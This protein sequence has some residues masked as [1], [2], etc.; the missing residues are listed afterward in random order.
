MIVT[1]SHNPHGYF[2]NPH[3]YDDSERWTEPYLAPSAWKWWPLRRMVYLF[4]LHRT[5][6]LT[7]VRADGTRIQPD[8]RFVTDW[9]STPKMLQIIAPSQEYPGYVL[10][11]CCFRVG[12]LWHAR[13]VL[14]STGAPIVNADTG[15]PVLTRYEFTPYTLA[16]ANGLLRDTILACGATEARAD[17][18]YCA[19]AAAAWIPWASASK[20]RQDAVRRKL[21]ENARAVARGE[22]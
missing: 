14:D 15:Q 10:H 13:P 3:G 12:G 7:Y 9:G 21:V 8:K 5:R 1:D 6:P 20:A 16:A 22:V 4:Q 2:V 19:V 18:I 17:L 11:D